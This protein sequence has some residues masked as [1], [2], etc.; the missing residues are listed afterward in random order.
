MMSISST[1]ILANMV[2]KMNEGIFFMEVAVGVLVD[3]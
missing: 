3:R 1:A 2:G